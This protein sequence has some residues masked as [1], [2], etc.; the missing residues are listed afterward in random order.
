MVDRS[1]YRG[2]WTA[3]IAGRH[4]HRFEQHSQSCWAGVKVA[5]ISPVRGPF[6]EAW[7]SRGKH[8]ISHP[9]RQGQGNGVQP[10]EAVALSRNHAEGKARVFSFPAVVADKRVKQYKLIQKHTLLV[11]NR[12]ADARA[13]TSQTSTENLD[14]EGER[15]VQFPPCSSCSRRTRSASSSRNVEYV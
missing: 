11:C 3:E 7:F 10:A 1:R 4:R 6:N 13:W 9:V 12:R 2:S 8:R 14:L 5:E 15:R